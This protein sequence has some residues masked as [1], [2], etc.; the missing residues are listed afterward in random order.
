MSFPFFRRKTIFLSVIGFEDAHE[1]F[2]SVFGIKDKTVLPALALIFATIF[3]AIST[4]IDT[5]IF[6]PALG[7]WILL[8]LT[9]ADILLG[10][11]ASKLVDRIEVNTWRMSRAGVRFIVQ[12]FFTFALFQIT[13]VWPIIGKWLVDALLFLFVFA[14][15]WSSFKNANRLGLIEEEAYRIVEKFL[16]VEA[17]FTRLF[18]TKLN[19][20]DSETSATE[21]T[22]IAEEVLTTTPTQ[23]NEIDETVPSHPIN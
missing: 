19:A 4:F 10:T 12:V 17:L 11:A 20:V 18:G 16:S 15:F 9:C 21:L 3:M 2:T 23:I 6:T 7:I 22:E 8:T 1:L 13:K 14:T 5:Y